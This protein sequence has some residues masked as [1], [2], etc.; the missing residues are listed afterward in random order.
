M[1]RSERSA[2]VL[3]IFSGSS[4]R[5]RPCVCIQSAAAGDG[6][7]DV[8]DVR[9]VRGR[10][11]HDLRAGEDGSQSGSGSGRDGDEDGGRE[12]RGRRRPRRDPIGENG[13]KNLSAFVH[14]D[15]L[16]EADYLGLLEITN[17]NPRTQARWKNKVTGGK[18]G[19]DAPYGKTEF[20]CSALCSCTCN[21]STNKWELKCNLKV[22]P[23]IYLSPDKLKEIKDDPATKD[24]DEQK[25]FIDKTYGHEQQHVLSA[26][27][28]LN[29]KK[30][31]WEKKY[32]GEFP[33]KAAC[34]QASPS[35]ATRQS[36]LR[37]ECEALLGLVYIGHFA[38]SRLIFK[39]KTIKIAA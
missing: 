33:N 31:E 32:E 7:H 1:V 3:W 8:R 16:N 24:K 19:L 22:T 6:L 26:T 14:N 25:E 38:C 17:P 9:A 35:L 4:L 28:R 34:E 37:K 10:L 36:E 18:E 39:E 11:Q 13:A 2:L 27:E 21:L 29:S 20:T 12:H 5:G 30:E 15:P 23:I